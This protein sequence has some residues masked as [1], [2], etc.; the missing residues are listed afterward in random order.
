MLL[1]ITGTRST[2]N[3]V[4][5]ATFILIIILVAGQLFT[6][7]PVAVL[8]AMIMTAVK[9]LLLQVDIFLGQ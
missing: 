9:G 2:L 6:A 7:L 4:F 1:S 5:T 3:G 8:A